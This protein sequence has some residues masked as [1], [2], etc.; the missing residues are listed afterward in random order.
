MPV[1]ADLLKALADDPKALEHQLGCMTG[2]FQIFDRP[3]L[4]RRYGSKRV[5]NAGS[6]MTSSPSLSTSASLSFSL[7]LSQ[8]KLK[9]HPYFRSI[10]TKLRLR[11]PAP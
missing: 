6:G 8:P 2:L 11:D 9:F 4:G 7:F 1:P 5:S 10:T 3:G